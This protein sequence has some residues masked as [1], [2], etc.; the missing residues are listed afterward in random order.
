MPTPRYVFTLPYCVCRKSTKWEPK[1]V[2]RERNFV[3]SYWYCEYCNRPAWF[4]QHDGGN[5]FI[6][7]RQAAVIMPHEIIA[8]VDSVLFRFFYQ[9]FR[10]IERTREAVENSFYIKTCE[11]LGVDPKQDRRATEP[12]IREKLELRMANLYC[13]ESWVRPAGTKETPFPPYVPQG[14]LLYVLGQKFQGKGQVDC[15]LCISSRA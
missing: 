12:S 4:I 7:P 10:H 6:V 15:W 14:A 1:E 3:I 11:W 5:A 2:Q 8:Y 13:D 9:N